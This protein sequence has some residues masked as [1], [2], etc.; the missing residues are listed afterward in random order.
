VDQ[1]LR[2]NCIYICLCYV[3]LDESNSVVEVPGKIIGFMILS[4]DKLIIGHFSAAVVQVG[5]VGS[6]QDRLDAVPA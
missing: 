1:N 4:R 2:N 6:S 5:A 3:L